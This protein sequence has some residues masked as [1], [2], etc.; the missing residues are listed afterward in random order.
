M[1]IATERAVAAAS[2]V[3]PNGCRSAAVTAARGSLTGVAAAG[4]S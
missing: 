3:N 2:Q 4:A 1:A